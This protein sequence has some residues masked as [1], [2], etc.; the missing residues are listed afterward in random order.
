[1]TFTYRLDKSKVN[2]YLLFFTY[3]IIVYSLSKIGGLILLVPLFLMAVFASVQFNKYT[4]Y[5][6][7]IVFLSLMTGNIFVIL[8]VSLFFSVYQLL[9][10]IKSRSIKLS[11]VEL[12]IISVFIV[13][14]I[15]YSFTQFI[16]SNLL[17]LPLYF[18]TF[19]SLLFTFYRLISL[20]ITEDQY[21]KLKYFI[22][23]SAIIQIGFAYIDYIGSVGFLNILTF[24]STPDEV[25]GTLGNA[26]N[27]A[28][29]CYTAAFLVMPDVRKNLQLKNIFNIFLMLFFLAFAIVADAKTYLAGFIFGGGLLYV[30]YA[31]KHYSKLWLTILSILIVLATAYL[32]PKVLK[33]SEPITELFYNMYVEG[34]YNHKYIYITRAFSLDNRSGFQYVFGTGPGTCGSRAANARAYNSLYKTEDSFTLSFLPPK[35]SKYADAILVDLY[36][37]K[38]A[39][40]AKFRSALLGNPFNSW[41]AFMIEFGLIGFMLMHILFFSLLIHVFRSKSNYSICAFL[42]ISSLY[43]ASWIDQV[44]ER[45]FPMIFMYLICAVA[46]SKKS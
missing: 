12:S 40:E 27:F 6:P 32:V 22:L 16:D 17:A 18:I 45:P 7:L 4:Q 2:R 25:K 34:E 26:N 11:I 3:L 30:L 37:Y 35:T 20:G 8:T 23:F 5:T 1:M 44:F 14:L 38:Y 21:R 31:F 46:L 33:L 9:V 28:I 10:L 24:K 36:Q 41:A 19:F 29:L 42:L 13:G 39:I 15:G 43:T